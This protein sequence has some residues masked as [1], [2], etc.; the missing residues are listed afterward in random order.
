MQL[1]LPSGLAHSPVV[2][3]GPTTSSIPGKEETHLEMQASAEHKAEACAAVASATHPTAWL[4]QALVF[5]TVV[6]QLKEK[7]ETC[8]DFVKE[9]WH[10]LPTGDKHS[11][12]IQNKQTCHQHLWVVSLGLKD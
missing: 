4:T 7:S 3:R 5:P 11:P 10:Y 6:P 12:S 8:L 2:S 9:K 1:T